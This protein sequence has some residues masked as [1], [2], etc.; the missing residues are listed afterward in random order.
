MN[1][2]KIKNQNDMDKFC[3]QMNCLA[4][5]LRTSKEYDKC[6]YFERKQELRGNK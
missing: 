2:L 6:D 3:K 5:N 1:K 4:C